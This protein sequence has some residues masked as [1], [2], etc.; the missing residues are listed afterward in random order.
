MPAAA[1]RG[2][3]I[4]LAALA[5]IIGA[6]AYE[7]FWLGGEENAGPA[8]GG[9]FTLVDQNGATRHDSDFRGKL[10]LVYFGYSNCPDACPT[11][12][13]AI[14]QTLD[15]LG[16][17]AARVQPIFI[18]IDPARDTPA[19]LKIYAGNFHPG[20]LYLT[21]TP[22]ALKTAESE[23][24]VYVQRVPQTAAED[25]LFDHSSVIYMLGA[26]GRYLGQMPTGL[27]PKA[28]AA[29]VQGYL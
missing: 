18:T 7:Q 25:E 5:V 21:G 14:G 27:P 19:Q 20:I 11:T 15:L 22:A 4:F 28:M 9:P 3:L 8:L 24:H 17:D 13:Q 10:M 26:N 1:R 6:V 23:Y 2:L 29:T 12:L 16:K